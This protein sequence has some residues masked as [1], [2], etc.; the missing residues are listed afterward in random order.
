MV[1]FYDTLLDLL[2]FLTALIPLLQFPSVMILE[3]I[4]GEH[5]SFIKM[6]EVRLPLIQSF[7]ILME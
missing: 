7:E 1:L 5:C 4:P 6:E 2:S 3:N